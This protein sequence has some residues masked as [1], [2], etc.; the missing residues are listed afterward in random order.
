MDIETFTD[1]P[2]GH[3]LR[4]TLRRAGSLRDMEPGAGLGLLRALRVN[5]RIGRGLRVL[6]YASVLL[7][8]F[9]LFALQLQQPARAQV[10]AMI[11]LPLLLG[12]WTLYGRQL[13]AYA[14]AAARAERDV[15][16]RNVK[17]QMQV[18]EGTRELLMLAQELSLSNDGL[19]REMDARAKMEAELRQ[20]QKLESVGRLAAGV[21]HE[22]NTP[23]QFVNDSV[24]FL[25]EGVNDLARLI[26]CYRAQLT[27]TQRSA[28][29]PLEADVDL[30]YLLEKLPK[31]IARCIEGLGRVAVIVRSMKEFAHP[32][33]SERTEAD[34]NQAIQSTLVIAR[35]EYKYV[36]DL[37]TDLNPLPPVPVYL[38]ELNQAVLNIVVNAA[39]AIGDKV[40]GTEQRGRITVQTRVEDDDVVIAIGDT[41]KGI[42]ES[43]R[44]KIFDPFF[45]T[46][47]VGRGTGQGL[48]VVHSVIVEKHRG[49]VDFTSV[50]GE[51]T[52]F[53]LRIPIHLRQPVRPG[54]GPR[55]RPA[56]A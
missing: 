9:I 34:I 20:A 39:H 15:R 31:A 21:A 53:Y 14:L 3:P 30:G 7:A 27:P 46:K 5:P 10:A 17:L 26:H 22:I 28:C 2:A 16:E 36:A 35:N 48:G 40:A 29:E 38:S 56:T 45:T 23:V 55:Q 47:D 41:G 51:G 42:P 13:R 8:T 1:L 12:A 18:T 6:M 50:P 19:R 11:L 49:R 37:E 24:H 25:S 43:I 52:T 32:D 54:T 44:E 33:S 4:E